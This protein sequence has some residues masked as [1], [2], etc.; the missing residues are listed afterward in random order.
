MFMAGKLSHVS[1]V[2]AS[3]RL[4]LQLY[5]VAHCFDA[6][7]TLIITPPY[8]FLVGFLACDNWLFGYTIYVYPLARMRSRYGS[9]P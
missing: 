9:M 4:H 2:C 6:P 5:L 8:R 1:T 3:K 7:L